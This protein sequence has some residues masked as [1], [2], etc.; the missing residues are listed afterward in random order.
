M[1]Q[2]CKRLLSSFFSNAMC[3]KIILPVP[4]IVLVLKKYFLILCSRLIRTQHCFK[5]LKDYKRGCLFPAIIL[6][7]V[8]WEIFFFNN[9]AYFLEIVLL[10][11][12]YGLLGSSF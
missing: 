9:I 4:N 10:Y 5:A 8:L 3:R 11:E 7:K 12:S 1:V 6:K 2:C